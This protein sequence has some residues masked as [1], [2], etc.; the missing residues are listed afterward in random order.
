MDRS[1]YVVEV[2]PNYPEASAA[3]HEL[4]DLGTVRPTLLE[5]VR[6]SSHH[7]IDFDADAVFGRF[8]ATGMAV[9][10]PVCVGLALV[11]VAV[12]ASMAGVDLS[13]G[14]AG[15]A[16]GV[17]VGL[18]LGGL[19]GVAASNRATETAELISE[20][21]TKADEIV[22]AVRGR[23]DS[24]AIRTVLERHGGHPAAAH[25]ELQA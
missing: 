18:L 20:I 7:V 23:R 21:P 15:A 4:I 13:L 6:P 24:D 12:A 17:V 9:G 11:I 25:F 22:V 14:A 5:S 10:V 16:G 19:F 2:L 3:V 1:D 8:V